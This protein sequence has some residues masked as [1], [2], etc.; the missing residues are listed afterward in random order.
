MNFI[1]ADLFASKIFD[2]KNLNFDICINVDSMQEMSRNSIEGYFNF[3]QSNINKDGIFYF[4]NHY[5]HGS[6]SIGEPED[7]P[8]DEHWKIINQRRP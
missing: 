6:D 4:K 8:F 5:G 2:I 1:S 7:Y 3:I